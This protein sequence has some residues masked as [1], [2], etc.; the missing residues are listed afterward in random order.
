[1]IAVNQGSKMKTRQG[2]FAVGLMA[3]GVTIAMAEDPGLPPGVI[4]SVP[5]FRLPD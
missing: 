1:M 4:Q 2:L 5:E 3:G